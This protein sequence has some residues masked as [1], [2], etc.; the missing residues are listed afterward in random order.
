M[1]S[2]A[3]ATSYIHPSLWNARDAAGLWKCL[4]ELQSIHDLQ[5][6]FRHTPSHDLIL[7]GGIL[8]LRYSHLLTTLLSTHFSV[9]RTLASDAHHRGDQTPAY[10]SNTKTHSQPTL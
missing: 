10:K 6:N 2:R 3:L 8:S 4:V 7:T 9:L 1:I 5:L